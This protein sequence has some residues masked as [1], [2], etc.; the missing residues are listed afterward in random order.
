MLD[1]LLRGLML[2]VGIVVLLAL[3]AIPIAWAGYWFAFGVNLYGG[4]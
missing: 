3:S 2:I 1:L 4:F